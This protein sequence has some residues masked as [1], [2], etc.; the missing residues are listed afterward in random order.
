[1]MAHIR[2]LIAFQVAALFACSAPQ[3][4][5]TPALAP[6][7][8]VH[9]TL[10]GA[11]EIRA[12]IDRLSDGWL[13]SLT[14]RVRMDQES[15]PITVRGLGRVTMDNGQL[16]CQVVE[17]EGDPGSRFDEAMCLDELESVADV[18]QSAEQAARPGETVVQEVQLRAR[19]P[20]R[21][22][23]RMRIPAFRE[24]AEITRDTTGRVTKLS[25]STEQNA[26]EE[27]QV[28]YPAGVTGRCLPTL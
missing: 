28:I 5:S 24:R 15:V 14:M 27:I 3:R 1:M 2:W 10:T 4:G 22:R 19:R 11:D 17:S 7:C 20:R 6:R 18:L 23:S 25:R 16:R 8:E 12:R 26:R 13:V 21:A 9:H